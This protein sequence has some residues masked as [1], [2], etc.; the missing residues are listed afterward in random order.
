MGDERERDT[1]EDD[2]QVGHGKI[3][4]EDVGDAAAQVL[5][6]QH[7]ERH[8][9]V[10]DQADA[11]HQTVGHAQDDADVVVIAV[12]DLLFFPL[13]VLAVVADVKNVNLIII[14]SF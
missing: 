12:P 10:A 7:C 11:E 8:Q 5:G 9:T 4:Q 3:N 6:P 13:A 1:G 14:Y 2:E